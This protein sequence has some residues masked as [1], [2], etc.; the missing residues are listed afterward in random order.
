MRDCLAKR[1]EEKG[2][3]MSLTSLGT[4]KRVG[5][6]VNLFVRHE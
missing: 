1:D 4:R 2:E 5:E 6:E 3:G